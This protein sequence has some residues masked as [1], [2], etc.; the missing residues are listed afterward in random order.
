MNSFAISNLP[1]VSVV[2]PCRNEEKTIARCIQSLQQQTYPPD[3]MEYIVAD[4]MSTDRTRSILFELA[5]R[6]PIL[7]VVD[8]PKLVSPAAMNVAIKI[9]RGSIIVLL[10]AH[11]EL[12]PDYI[13]QAVDILLSRQEI[14]CVGGKIETISLNSTTKAIALAMSSPFGIGDAKFRYSDKTE[15]VDT[16]AFGAYRREIFDQIGYF[17]EG[18]PR[19]EDDE[20]NY[21]LRK[22]GGQILLSPKLRARYYARSSLRKLWQQYYGYGR[23]KVWVAHK[24]FTMMRPRHLIPALFM[25]GLLTTAILS[26][27]S[28]FGIF[29]FGFYL[30]TYLLFSISFSVLVVRQHGWKY[31]WQLPLLFFILHTSYGVGTLNGFGQFIW[32]YYEQKRD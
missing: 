25:L 6:V 4:G 16:V 30:S 20:F 27:F 18:L 3:R 28:Q 22:A 5:T 11:A 10:G 19:N 7:R 13:L 31:L 24:H 8:N 26:L 29:L 32:K 2:I 21:R 12:E 9:A 23:G 17:E 15:V 14:A 1:M